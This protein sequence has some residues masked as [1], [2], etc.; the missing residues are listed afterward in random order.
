MNTHAPWNDTV[1]GKAQ[2][3]QNALCT[4]IHSLVM[5]DGS[6]RGFRTFFVSPD[7]TK[8]TCRR[9]LKALAKEAK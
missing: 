4:P 2:W 6:N 1:N 3:R 5:R 9:C 7:L 8:V